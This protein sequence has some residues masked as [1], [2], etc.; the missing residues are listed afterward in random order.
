MLPMVGFLYLT[1]LSWQYIIF[2]PGLVLYFLYLFIWHRLRGYTGD[3]CGAVCL[4]VELTVYLV[5]AC[6]VTHPGA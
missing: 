6:L 2:L 4:L 3:C 1:G 5:V